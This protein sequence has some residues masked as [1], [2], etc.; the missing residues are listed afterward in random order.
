M[1]AD[2]EK[3]EMII[4]EADEKMDKTVNFLKSDFLQ[5]R[6]GRANPHVLDKV[7]VDY[8]GQMTP[9]NQVGNI[10]VSDGK[11]LVIAPWDKSLLKNVEKALRVSDIGI[12]PIND[13]NVIRL[14]FPD[15]TEERRRDLVKQVKKMAEDAKVA[16]RNVRRDALDAFKKMKTAKE[17][18]DDEYAGF[19]TQVEKSTSK[20]IDTIDKVSQEKE[21]ELMT[22]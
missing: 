8:Y 19:E 11:C 1:A 10:S 15:L 4:L 22:V 14:V 20:N 13:G 2:M 9:I 3:V 7:Q 6:A 17:I 16:V 21:K 12:N 5:I 18:T